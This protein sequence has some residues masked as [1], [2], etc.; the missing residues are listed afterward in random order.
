MTEAIRAVAN[1]IPTLYY[2]ELPVDDWDPYAIELAP[3]DVA[4]YEGRWVTIHLHAE[5]EDPEQDPDT[6]ITM[7]SI[8]E[9]DMNDNELSDL[10]VGPMPSIDQVLEALEPM[11]DP[12][13]MDKDDWYTDD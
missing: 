2:A 8:K 5:I 10:D 6:P 7:V 4:K 9:L 12:F 13:M 1:G 11:L 3:H